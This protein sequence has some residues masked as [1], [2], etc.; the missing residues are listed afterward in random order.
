VYCCHLRMRY[1]PLSSCAYVSF[2]HAKTT[3]NPSSKFNR[4]TFPMCFLKLRH[5]TFHFDTSPTSRLP[6]Q[7]VTSNFRKSSRNT[8]HYQSCQRVLVRTGCVYFYTNIDSRYFSILTTSYK[9]DCSFRIKSC[10]I[11]GNF[12]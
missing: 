9:P 6:I 10:N 12:K 5:V 2:D 8:S 3:P 11:S 1:G 7:I 4:R